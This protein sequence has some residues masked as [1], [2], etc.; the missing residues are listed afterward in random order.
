V[1]LETTAQFRRCL[2][3]FSDERMESILATM[4]AAAGAYGRPHLHAGIGLRIIDDF[5]ECRDA[6]DHRLLFQRDGGSLVFR[7]YGTH[8]AVRAFLRNRRS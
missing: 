1:K 7:F 4:R 5:I 6:L 3:G 2:R 8:D